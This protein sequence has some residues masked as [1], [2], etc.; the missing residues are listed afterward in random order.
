VRRGRAAQRRAPDYSAPMARAPLRP[1]AG[2]PD[3]PV[4]DADAVALV[5]AALPSLGEP[6]RTALALVVLAG[7]SRAQVAVRLGRDEAALSQALAGARKELRR[8]VAALPGSGWCEHAERLISDRIDGVLAAGDVARLDVHLRNCPRCVEH[9]R[10]LVQATDA[11]VASAA[12]AAFA[13]AGSPAAAPATRSTPAASGP[14]EAGAP[15]EAETS[16]LL[17]SLPLTALIAFTVLLA[18]AALVVAAVA[19]G[20]QL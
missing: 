6:Q 18:L 12:G 19:L 3:R 17:R 2:Q 7:L 5:A 8:S 10:R 14:A 11:L 20:L 4:S 16:S 9:E 1:V 15:P 13:P